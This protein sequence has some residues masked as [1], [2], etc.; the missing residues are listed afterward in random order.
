ME[1]KAFF[2]ATVLASVT[3][4]GAVALRLGYYATLDVTRTTAT[5]ATTMVD[6]IKWFAGEV[7]RIDMA[8]FQQ[9]E[10]ELRQQA[11]EIFNQTFGM[12]TSGVADILKDY[13]Y[14]LGAEDWAII[15]EHLNKWMPDCDPD[16]V[17]YTADE[18]EPTVEEV[19][20]LMN[21]PAPP[22]NWKSKF[23]AGL[24]RSTRSSRKR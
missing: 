19:E 13:E 9:K 17:P 20:I 16:T 5:A 4:R 14:M 11:F 6:N 3:Q 22:S 18:E 8:A 12:I 7:G 10:K 2:C 15:Q 21:A 1:V 23:Q 24:R